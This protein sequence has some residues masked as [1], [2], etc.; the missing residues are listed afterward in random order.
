MKFL[1]MT[2]QTYFELGVH[3]TIKLKSMTNNRD[4]TMTLDYFFGPSIGQIENW[5]KK[6][7]IGSSVVNSRLTEA[8][9]DWI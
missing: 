1:Q 7:K 6:T 3:C 4:I 5:K 8:D 9:W 2:F